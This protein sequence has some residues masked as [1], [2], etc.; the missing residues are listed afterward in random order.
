MNNVG[1]SDMVW[2]IVNPRFGLPSFLRWR[3]NEYAAVWMDRG[4]AEDCGY[5]IEEI[6]SDV[7]KWSEN[8]DTDYEPD[9]D[10][11]DRSMRRTWLVL[12]LIGAVALLLM[13]AADHGWWPW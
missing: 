12:A 9:W 11:F 4:L 2:A 13:T 7:T 6:G 1:K 8:A 5:R 10:A 3:S